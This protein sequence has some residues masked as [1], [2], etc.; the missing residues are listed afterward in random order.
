MLVV[1]ERV[2]KI[3]H[4]AGQDIQQ[5]RVAVS[6]TESRMHEPKM[7]EPRPRVLECQAVVLIDPV[8]AEESACDRNQSLSVESIV[9][10]LSGQIETGHELLDTGG[11]LNR[12]GQ[13]YM[14][15][16]RVIVQYLG[17]QGIALRMPAARLITFGAD[18]RTWVD[19]FVDPWG[20][21][22]C[23]WQSRQNWNGLLS[24][25]E[26]GPLD[27]HSTIVETAVCQKSAPI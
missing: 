27:A 15:I 21:F 8:I 13:S 24:T 20:P 1:L 17:K 5:D 16:D 3:S 10:Q 23:P 11:H 19:H 7:F 12:I 18:F 26:T 4:H 22:P 2:L 9:P 6:I 14:P 25:L